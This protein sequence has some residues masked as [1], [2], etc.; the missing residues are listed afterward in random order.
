MDFV[1]KENDLAGLFFHFLKNCLEPVF[2][3]TPVLGPGNQQAKIKRNDLFT[4]Q[5][6]WNITI[7]NS[8]GQP[9]DNGCLSDTRLTDEDRIV[10]CPSTKHLDD[11]ADFLIAAD[12]RIKFS[13][14][15]YVGQVAGIFFQGLVFFFR[16]LVRHALVAANG[17]QCLQKS[18][19]GN[20]QRTQHLCRR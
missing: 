10:F 19:T 18:I 7:D 12:D 4:F 8:L 20:A 9:F 6:C 15:G 13:L 14:P 16:V 5:G 3:F 1:N 11:P 2:K 17:C